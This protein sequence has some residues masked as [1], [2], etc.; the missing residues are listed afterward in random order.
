V[1]GVV[2]E[3]RNYLLSVRAAEE[4]D[5]PTLQAFALAKDCLRL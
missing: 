2:E 3:A 4:L 5:P 1:D